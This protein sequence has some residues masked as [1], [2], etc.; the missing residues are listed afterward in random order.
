MDASPLESS[1]DDGRGGARSPGGLR[2]NVMSGAAW[3]GA[4]QTSLQVVQIVTV[5]VLARL[6]SPSD[7][8][9]V[10]MV[11]VFAS[12]VAY[13][14]DLA[15]VAALVQRKEITHEHCAT[16][17]WTNVVAGITVTLVGIASAPLVARFFNEPR[18]EPLLQVM[19]LNFVVIALGKTQY[20]LLQR[21]MRFR[22]TETRL[23]ISGVVGAVVGITLAFMGAGPWALIA[24]IMAIN[25]VRTVLVWVASDWRP[26]FTFSLSAWRDIRSFSRNVLATNILYFLNGN[27]DNL[28]IG[29][30]L[31]PA[32]L[33]VY[34]L[35]YNVMLQPIYRIVIPIRNVLFPAF[36]KMQDDRPRMLAGWI[37]VNR[38]VLGI[39]LPALVGLVATAP[40][41]VATA[42]GHKWHAAAAV[43][44]ALAAVGVLQSVQRLNDSVMQACNQTGLQLIFAATAF[45]TNIVAFLI[46]VRFGVLGVAVGA[47][48][49]SA[50]VQPLYTVATA[51]ALGTSAWALMRGVEGVAAAAACMGAAV[52]GLRLGLTDIH[53]PVQGRLALEVVAGVTVFFALV[54]W[55]DRPLMNEYWSIFKGIRRRTRRVRP[56]PALSMPD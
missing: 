41:F 16:A 39:C 2:R 34:R 51:R 5:A 35:A 11:M 31:G 37:R 17:F 42:F 36:S 14:T 53:A 6:L 50:M 49:A 1:P 25:A 12:L 45:V 30:F 9:V 27:A 4:S 24:Q 54:R 20:A 10:G 7:F 15:F 19:S 44:M 48:I 22:S 18:V 3:K 26:T 21:E 38:V 29:K 43:I 40:D 23:I 52:L 33:G 56:K 55:F 32:P 8:G 47:A 46:G 28:I 13:F